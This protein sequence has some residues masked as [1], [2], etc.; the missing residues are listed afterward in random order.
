MKE[1]F[2]QLRFK[3]YWDSQIKEADEKEHTYSLHDVELGNRKAKY[4]EIW[5]QGIDDIWIQARYVRPIGM[6]KV[7]LVFDFHDEGKPVQGW[8][9]L[10]RYVAL[11]Y[12]VIAMESRGLPVSNPDTVEVTRLLRYHRTFMD[13]Y[14][15]SRIMEKLVGIDAN[16]MAAFGRGYGGAVAMALSVLRPDIKK[17]S[18]EYPNLCCVQENIR[19][20]FDGDDGQRQEDACGMLEYIDMLNFAPF[21]KAEVLMGTAML[22]QVASPDSQKKVFDRLTCKKRQVLFPRHEHE[23]INFFED[24]NLRFLSNLGAS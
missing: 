13:A 7:P 14:I 10:T 5:F 12:A 16:H 2:T 4:Q 20:Q 23:L 15:L 3:G 21:V 6:D 11:G 24:E 1:S 22:N 18:M 19:I 8:F 9:H 17:C